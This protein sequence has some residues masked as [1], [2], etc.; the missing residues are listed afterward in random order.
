[1]SSTEKIQGTVEAWESGELGLDERYV[2][3]VDADLEAQI[4]A[5]VGM[6]AISIRL[7]KSMIEAY[8]ALASY[9]GVGYQPLM[10]DVLQRFVDSEMRAIAMGVIESQA[11]THP[12]TT[13]K[14]GKERDAR[15]REP[16]V[17]NA[18]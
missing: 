1:M 5:A 14:S 10:R 18:A 8:K 12:Q 7:E 4:D 11:K 6:Q 17:K 16:K 9:H 2:S 15:A 13:K 3:R